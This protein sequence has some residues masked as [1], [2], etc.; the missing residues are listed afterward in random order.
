MIQKNIFQSWYTT[1]L[2]PNLKNEINLFRS[3]NPDYSYHLYTDDDMDEFVNKNFQGDISECYNKLNIIVAKVD[4]WRY[5]ILYKYGGIYLDMDSSITKTLNGLIREEDQAIISSE[6]SPYY[7]QWALIFSKQHPILKK[8]IELIVDN[9]KNNSYPN[10]IHK[11][12]GPYIYTKAINNYHME[13]FGNIIDKKK[14]KRDTNNIYEKDN[15]SYR[16]YGIDYNE[17]FCFKHSNCGSMYN[18]KK[19][20]REEQKEIKLLNYE[21]KLL[22]KHIINTLTNLVPYNENEYGKEGWYISSDKN[23]YYMQHDLNKPDPTQ[24]GKYEWEV[25]CGPFKLEDM[26]EKEKVIKSTY[27]K[28]IYFL[29]FAYFLFIL[30]INKLNLN[31]NKRCN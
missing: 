30:K 1:E 10:N 8:V 7:V 23:L 22:N 27:S 4:F 14:I 29:F 26:Q 25:I 12:T 28:K 18:N 2:D 20:W 17:Y 13:V 11:M 6:G 3:M 5:L 21:T 15:I 24:E 16:L 31:Y 19:H 9:I